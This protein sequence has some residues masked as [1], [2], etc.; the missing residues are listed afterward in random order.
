MTT[1]AWDAHT[2]NIETR[3]F[4]DTTVA[5]VCGRIDH[6]NAAD[7]EAALAPI[8]QQVG[9]TKAALVLDLA[10]VDYISS[11]GLRVLML[12]ARASR[13]SGARLALAAAQSVVAE[14]FAISRFDRMLSLY[15]D[16]PAALQQVS[17]AARTAYD[18]T[19]PASAA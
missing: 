18:A 10:G 4:A 17:P 14:I 12:A 1:A 9:E 11:V 15:A 16:V 13:A 2:V 5:A 8:L 7:F 6:R 3:Q 19:G